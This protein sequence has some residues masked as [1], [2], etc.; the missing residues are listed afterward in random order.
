LQNDGFARILQ[1]RSP[2]IVLK[3]QIIFSRILS[4]RFLQYFCFLG[5]RVTTLLRLNI[6]IMLY[7]WD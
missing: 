5:V 6:T 4:F 1:G 3:G 2:Q 7:T